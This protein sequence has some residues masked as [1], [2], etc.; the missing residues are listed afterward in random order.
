MEKAWGDHI[1]GFGGKL[2]G[3][4]DVELAMPYTSLYTAE[5]HGLSSSELEDRLCRDAVYLASREAE[6]EA[7]WQTRLTIGLVYT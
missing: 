7:R 4:A 6:I 3:N 2:Q 1:L 5:W